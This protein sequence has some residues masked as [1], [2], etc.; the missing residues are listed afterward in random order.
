[1]KVSIIPDGDLIQV[2]DRIK[3]ENALGISWY[4]VHRVTPKYAFVQYNDVAEG[5]YPRKANGVYFS[6]LPREKWSTTICSAW[7]PVKKEPW[8]G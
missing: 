4:V 2:G 8:T 6:N 1:M 5:R 3:H 7:R